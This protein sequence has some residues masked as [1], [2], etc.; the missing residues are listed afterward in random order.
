MKVLMNRK[1]NARNLKELVKRIG[2]EDE[3]L[4]ND[5]L[6]VKGD[7]EFSIEVGNSKYKIITT[8]DRVI[9]SGD[10]KEVETITNNNNSETMDTTNPTAVETTPAI[11]TVQKLQDENGRSYFVKPD[12]TKF[13]YTFVKDTTIVIDSYNYENRV[14]GFKSGA[15]RKTVYAPVS[16][17]VDAWL[18]THGYDKS[19]ILFGTPKSINHVLIHNNVFNVQK[20]Q[21]GKYF[22]R[23]VWEALDPKKGLIEQP[24]F[25]NFIWFKNI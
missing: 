3:D 10:I 14:I 23:M 6:N 4:A 24:N 18:K 13:K 5:I 20:S 8:P 12:G 2:I 11:N 15:H 19:L 9:L 7:N 17:M 1:I 25:K 21:S 16:E 22:V